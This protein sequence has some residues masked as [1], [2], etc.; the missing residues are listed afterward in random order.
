MFDGEAMKKVI[1]LITADGQTVKVMLD[2]WG[3]G[4]DRLHRRWPLVPGG[5][6]CVDNGEIAQSLDSLT[7]HPVKLWDAV[8]RR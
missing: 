8:R 5:W 1:K 2:N 4:M 7:S 3:G 6:H